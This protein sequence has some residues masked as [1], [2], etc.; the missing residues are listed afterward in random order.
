MGRNY[1]RCSTLK[2]CCARKQVEL[3]QENPEEYIVSYIGEHIH[4]R[5]TTRRSTAGGARD[6]PPPC[7]APPTAVTNLSSTTPLMVHCNSKTQKLDRDNDQIFEEEE[8]GDFLI[9]NMQIS[10]ETFMAMDV[11]NSRA[12][13]TMATKPHYPIKDS[14]G[15]SE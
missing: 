10:E 11:P 12:S 9:P 5:P 2:A 14:S 4:A 15:R 6:P 8:G 3:S 1:Y 13:Q 7:S